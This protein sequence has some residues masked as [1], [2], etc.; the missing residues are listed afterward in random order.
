MLNMFDIKVEDYK[1]V[2]DLYGSRKLV[3]KW[4]TCQEAEDL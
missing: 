2:E 1:K 3:R 4:K